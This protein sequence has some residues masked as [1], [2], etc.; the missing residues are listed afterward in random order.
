[1]A[2]LMSVIFGSGAPLRRTVYA[3]AMVLVLPAV[4]AAAPQAQSGSTPTRVRA[5]CTDCGTPAEQERRKLLD[6]LDS[7]RWEFENVRLTDEQRTELRLE[8]SRTM[9][10]LEKALGEVRAPSS[11]APRVI[12]RAQVW[13]M[14][15]A[16]LLV[17]RKNTRG[18]LGV[19]FDG[20][21]TDQMRDSER[22]IRFYKYPMIALVEPRSPAERAG[23]RQGDTLLA[24]NGKDVVSGEISLT[25]L[26]VPDE[27]LTVR[28]KRDGSA[29]DVKVTVGRAPEY[30]IRRTPM[31][32]TAPLLAKEAAG[33]VT[34]RL[35]GAPVAPAPSAMPGVPAVPPAARPSELRAPPVPERPAVPA[36]YSY[37]WNYS[38]GIGGARV[39]TV[40]E[41]LAKALGVQ[42]GVLVV[43]AMAGTMAHE[44]GLRDGDVIVA[45][46]GRAIS[47]VRELRS[48]VAD[49][50]AASGV[51]LRVL[52]ERRQRDIT[53]RW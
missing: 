9:V 32:A 4:A 49:H 47:N 30:V 16:D 8:M 21:N 22:I 27:R 14:P 39:E 1:M 33:D 25:R 34:Y 40:T 15:D 44:A 17:H 2:N 52:R 48:A 11:P 7:L 28:V 13:E 35:P 42:A 50:H 19:S 24:L 45:V 36:G 31:P 51:K 3:V 37:S 46:A 41:G 26:L 43:R 18:Y 29:R 10:E 20:P 53:L 12:T 5:G 38:E 6:R 23:I